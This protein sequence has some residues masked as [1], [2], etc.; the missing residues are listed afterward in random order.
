MG[1]PWGARAGARA[2]RGEAGRS[3]AGPGAGPGRPSSR[4]VGRRRGARAA[5]GGARSP[6]VARPRR[7]VFPDGVLAAAAGAAMDALKSAGRAL[8]RSPSLAKQ[9]WGGG[10]RHRS[11]CVRVRR[12]GRGSGGADRPPAGAGGRG[13]VCPVPCGPARSCGVGGRPRSSRAPTPVPA[14]GGWGG[15][16]ELGERAELGDP[17]C[18]RQSEGPQVRGRDL[19]EPRHLAASPRWA[20]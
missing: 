6:R 14:L 9:S 13:A 8:I 10:G 15:G 12:A 3:G 4:P 7:K 19:R 2:G 11:E 18:R 16:A 17:R 1:T 5:G 20:A